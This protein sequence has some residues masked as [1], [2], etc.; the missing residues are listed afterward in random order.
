MCSRWKKYGINKMELTQIQK[1]KI[2]EQVLVLNPGRMLD[3]NNAHEM[4]ETIAAALTEG[5]THIVLDMSDLEFLSSAGVGSILGTVD[6]CR[7][8]GG[9][10]IICCAS[11]TILHVFETLDLLEY[12]TIRSDVTAALEKAGASG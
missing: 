2:T 4:V 7:E 10:I 9:D 5:Y 11:G 12:L 3:N 1:R 6:S 8:R